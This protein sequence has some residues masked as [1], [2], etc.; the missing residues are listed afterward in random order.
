MGHSIHSPHPDTH[1]HG[2]HDGCP[3]CEEHAEHPIQSL[4][5]ANLGRI[6]RLAVDP[7][8]FAH[9]LSH[10]E[11]VAAAKVLSTLEKVGPLYRVAPMEVLAMLSRY[12]VRWAELL[13][14]DT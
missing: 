11:L 10:L 4:D 7:N 9:A 2:L 8:R 1:T 3:R 5:D 12:G 6:V 13:A 14:E